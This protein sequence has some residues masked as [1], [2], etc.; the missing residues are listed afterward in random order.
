MKNK[1]TNVLSTIG[2]VL[3]ILKLFNII[4]WSWWLILF[5]FYGLFVIVVGF[6]MFVLLVTLIRNKK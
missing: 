3:V 6:A 2:I 4:S 5:P 1:R